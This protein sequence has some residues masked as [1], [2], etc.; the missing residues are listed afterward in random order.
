MR[1]IFI[2]SDLND[3][4]ILKRVREF[5][6]NGYDVSIFAINRNKYTLEIDSKYNCKII[7]HFSNATPYLIRIP[8]LLKLVK[9]AVKKQNNN[10]CYY[11]FGLE[12]AIAYRFLFKIKKYKYIYEEC[13]ML[14]ENIH[15]KCISD[16]L[17]KTDKKI[18]K[19]SLLSVFTSEG[20]VKYH[21]RV[22]EISNFA[23]IPNKLSEEIVDCEDIPK[24]KSNKLR[25]GFVGSI[26]YMSI[27]NFAKVLCENFPYLDFHFY[28][29]FSAPVSEKLFEPLKQY[30]NCYFHGR[31]SKQKDLPKIYSTLDLV[32]STYDTNSI[33]VRFAEPNKLYEAIYFSTPIIVSSGT[34]LSEKVH[35]LG[36]GFSINAMNDDEIISFVKNLTIEMVQEKRNNIIKLGREYAISNNSVFFERISKLLYNEFDLYT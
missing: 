9:A 2:T 23:I 3:P 24:E 36:V 4:R 35:E 28:G 29:S 12:C 17:E 7:G 11:I 31:F 20:F 10:V 5:Y 33:N 6:T 32:L 21:F 1:I 19:D 8:V 30:S 16:Y 14:H 27:K 34:F 18:I 25:I 26:R 13:D 22:N 15:N